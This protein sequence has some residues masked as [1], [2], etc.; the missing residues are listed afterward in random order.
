MDIF[1]FE[2]VDMLCGRHHTFSWKILCRALLGLLVYFGALSHAI[3]LEPVDVNI[4]N[5]AIDLSDVYE[6]YTSAGGGIRVKTA[7]DANGVVSRI[8]VRSD[9]AQSTGRWIAFAL[10]NNSESQI[11]RLIV[12]PHFRLS[13]SGFLWP[14]LGSDRIVGITPSEGFALDRQSSND[15]DVFRITLNPGTVV[16]FVA[17]LASDELPQLT[18]WEPD[19]YKDAVNSYTLYEGIVL[20]IAG[21]LALFLTILFVVKGSAMF[22]AT[23][24]LAWAV[25]AYICVDFGFISKI[26]ALEP[27]E[28]NIW[29]AGTEVFLSAS[30]L[31][32]LYAYLHLNRWN[33]RYSYLVTLWLLGLMALFG[34]A[35][36]SPPQAAGIARISFA[37][38]SGL[39]LLLILGLAIRG[40]DRAI[41]LIPT[42][43]L[44]LTWVTAAWMTVTG[45]LDND[46]I[47]PALG[48]GLVLIILLISFTV[49]QHAFAGG[50]LVQG[51]V[52]D[53]ERRALAL[54]G[55]GDAVWDWDVDRDTIHVDSEIETSLGLKP[56]TLNASPNDWDVLLHPDDREKFKS[57]LNI[58]L[59]H[60]RGRLIQD[61]RLRSSSGAYHWYS[62]K[63]RP[64]IGSNGEVLRCVGTINDVS[65][66]RTAQMRLL[67]DA[68][69]DNLT[70]LPNQKLFEDRLANSV[71]LAQS[72]ADLRPSLFLIDFDRF[73]QINETLG[74]AT[75]DSILLTMVRR[76]SRLLKSQDSL[77][78]LN[79]DQFALT[80]VSEKEPDKIAV[81]ADALRRSIAAPINFSDQEITITASIG[82]VTWSGEQ[83][84]AE[85]MF[86]DATLASVQAKRMGGNRI[87]PFR[88]AFRTQADPTTDLANDLR[89]ALARN[90]MEVHFQPIVNLNSKTVAGFETK[91]CWRHP[92]RGMLQTADFISAAQKSGQMLP[93]GLFALESA[94]AA[95]ANWQKQLGDASGFVLVDLFSSEILRQDLVNDVKAIVTK[96]RLKPYSLRVGFAESLIMR[97]PEQSSHVIQKVKE[98]GIGLSVSDFGAG[99]SSLSHVT[100]FPFDTIQI[101]KAF[102]ARKDGNKSP[103]LLR[104]IVG[105][106]QD[107]NMS[108][109]ADGVETENDALDLHQLGCEL[110][111][112]PLYGPYVPE[113]QAIVILQKGILPQQ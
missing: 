90:E 44:T 31:V 112:G 104:S 25:L 43:I 77:A 69:F 89:D 46:I 9:K 51:L 24:A 29:R 95:L 74:L 20:G 72:D 53:V 83:T 34:M 40:F 45:R 16:T 65:S 14:D 88:P 103:N 21:L 22:P 100:R 91:L 36:I 1:E 33:T 102:V 85:D 68:V 11:D 107:L 28:L 70:G 111:Q 54:V 109:I 48:G 37:V 75:G 78:R 47:Q 58:V 12:A 5:P 52:S 86:K 30:L 17:E 93:L 84:S 6:E 98:I 13:N 61:I 63:A 23:A 59:D 18:V 7:P 87:E 60:R 92:K 3:A 101:S 76:M 73:T 50:T 10:A 57:T 66:Q 99:V 35:I 4:D 56:G 81:F 71:V 26:V 32:F 39:G 19:A 15:S 27:G 110:A 2:T 105:M 79:G 94:G 64:V 113:K 41:L 8:E 108:A 49:M 62:I 38:L 106:A 67:N 82:L 42:W 55:S 96:Y 97:N 80:L